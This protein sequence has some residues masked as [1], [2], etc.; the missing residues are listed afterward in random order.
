MPGPDD[1]EPKD[2]GSALEFDLAHREDVAIRERRLEKENNEHQREQALRGIAAGGTR[3]LLR[4]ICGVLIVTILIVA[5]Y[6]LAPEHLTQLFL[7]L[8]GL[9]EGSFQRD[10]YLVGA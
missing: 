8:V 10:W 7:F 5:W 1:T 4:T 9:A 6:H 2:T 3:G